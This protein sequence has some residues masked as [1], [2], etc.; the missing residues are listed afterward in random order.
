LEILL[1]PTKNRT[2]PAEFKVTEIIVEIPLFIFPETVGAL[3]EALS[4]ALVIVTV[5]VWVS[6]SAP[7]ETVTTTRYVLFVSPSAGASKSGA[8]AKVK[9]PVEELMAKSPASVPDIENERVAPASTSV[10][11]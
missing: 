3:I 10:A 9:T 8:M 5:R 6:E 2:F 7:S 1:P 11:V 4:L